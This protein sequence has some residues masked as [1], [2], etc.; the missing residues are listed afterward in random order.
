MPLGLAPLPVRL[1][2]SLPPPQPRRLHPPPQRLRMHRQPVFALQVLARQRG[3]EIFVA[4]PHSRQHSLAKLLP[5]G[6][7]RHPPAVAVLQR[8][9]PA[10]AILRPDP[11]HL[12]ITHLQQLCR[13]PQSQTLRLHPPHDLYSPQFFPA[14]VRSPQSRSLLAEGTLK[15]D[16]SNVVSGGH[17]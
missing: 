1:A 7:I 11:L 6:S 2:L 9:G 8:S 5:V 15:G 12:P 16:I 17:F 14:Q 10:L 3:P 13:F 4:L